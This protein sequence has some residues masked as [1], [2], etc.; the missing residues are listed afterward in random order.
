MPIRNNKPKSKKQ[1]DS[2][3]VEIGPR[4]D[5]PSVAHP[6]F[7]R[8]GQK[9]APE[10]EGAR[11][12]T[13]AESHAVKLKI[14]RRVQLGAN[15]ADAIRKRNSV[16]TKNLA[17]KTKDM[18][19][20][21]PQEQ[22]DFVARIEHN[23]KATEKDRYG[24]D[25]SKHWTY[26]EH[27]LRGDV[28]TLL[29]N[30]FPIPRGGKPSAAR[31]Q[32]LDAFGQHWRDTAKYLHKNREAEHISESGRGKGPHLH[33]FK[34]SKEGVT[35]VLTHPKSKTYT[36]VYEPDRGK[37]QI[38]KYPVYTPTVKTF[39]HEVAS[40]YNLH[41]IGASN[42]KLIK[43]GAK[44]RL[45]SSGLSTSELAK[46]N[47]L[48]K[49]HQDIDKHHEALHGYKQEEERD[50]KTNKITEKARHV[51]GLLEHAEGHRQDIAAHRD[52]IT[53]KRDTIKKTDKLFKEGKIPLR[54]HAKITGALKDQIEN[55]KGALHESKSKLA[56]V[57]GRIKETTAKHE[58]ALKALE[59]AK[60]QRRVQ[61]KI[62]SSRGTMQNFTKAVKEHGGEHDSKTVA[63][64]YESAKKAWVD[65]SVHRNNQSHPDFIKANHTL[66]GK[67]DSKDKDERKGIIRKYPKSK[68]FSF[69]S[70]TSMFGSNSGYHKAVID[71][72][73]KVGARINENKKRLDDQADHIKHETAT[74]ASGMRKTLVPVYKP[75]SKTPDGVPIRQTSKEEISKK[76]KR[77]FKHSPITDKDKSNL[78]ALKKKHVSDLKD[79][80]KSV[81]EYNTHYKPLLHF[82]I[83]RY[84]KTKPVDDARVKATTDK[85][86]K[87][88]EE[89][90]AERIAKV[91]AKAKEN[92]EAGIVN[93][94]ERG[95]NE[96]KGHGTLATAKRLKDKGVVA[97]EK[98]IGTTAI[99]KKQKKS[100]MLVDNKVYLRHLQRQSKARAKKAS[101]NKSGGK[102]R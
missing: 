10:P 54:A 11:E 64:D 100:D 99:K 63:E 1:P 59:S 68:K 83:D 2:T 85:I 67:P 58:A 101:R 43:D 28:R 97:A 94:N 53:S 34:Y 82:H 8:P 89:K 17:R 36:E 93:R 30:S 44:Q 7:Q 12:P 24:N 95:L 6:K 62:E 66:H 98:K 40:H 3:H 13:P 35:S 92:K 46:G 26:P 5:T 61:R 74:V 70:P 21:T 84:N 42:K 87:D 78:E 14:K 47:D 38:A 9:G 23:K 77:Y 73:H 86:A 27:R 60:Q 69:T 80:R 22:A 19:P 48:P 71:G 88:K 79:H 18:V 65:Y 20:R 25:K 15:T 16:A 72:I 39:H 52:L 57:N 41:P 102:R 49:L 45:V 56:D 51:P 55:V 75:E 4:S 37:K 96:E 91:A 81:K 32:V 76:D 31:K 90:K 29:E 50:P 33:D